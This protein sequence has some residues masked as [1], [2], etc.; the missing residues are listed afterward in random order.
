MKWLTRERCGDSRA[1]RRSSSGRTA[2]PPAFFEALEQRALLSDPTPIALNAAGSG[3]A[4]AVFS[5]FYDVHT[6]SFVAPFS[7]IMRVERIEDQILLSTILTIR[8]AGGRATSVAATPGDSQLSA[9]V[10]RDFAR[11]T[12][13]Q[14]YIIEIMMTGGNTSGGSAHLNVD[15]MPDDH[16]DT[17]EFDKATVI[18]E[19]YGTYSISA[20]GVLEAATD[21]DLFTFTASSYG[22]TD[23]WVQHGSDY[24]TR[25]VRVDVSVFDEDHRLVGSFTGPYS[26]DQWGQV[27]SSGRTVQVRG[28][29]GQRF[30]A[31]VTDSGTN[32]GSSKGDANTYRVQ[33]V[34]NQPSSIPSPLYAPLGGA[35]S[36][37]ANA[38]GDLGLG[39]VS[40]TGRPSMFIEDAGAA[41]S[42]ADL[43]ALVG[44]SKRAGAPATWADPKDNSVGVAAPMSD[45][46]RLAWRDASGGWHE[47]NLT[48]EVAGAGI[49]ASDVTVFTTRD[50][51]LAVS[52]LGITGDLLLY[53]QTGAVGAGGRWEW[54]FT[55]LAANDLR[56]H[57]QSMPKL[58]G[59]LTSYVTDWNGLNIAALDKVGRVQVIWWAPGMEHWRT[60]DLSAL[61]GAPALQ[62]SLSSY[63][64]PWGGINLAG[65]DVNGKVSVTWWAPG[66][67]TWATSNLSD[68]IGGPVLNAGSVA[69]YVTRWGG[70]NV[71]GL[72]AGGRVVVYW[73]APG[74]DAWR[75]DSIS[76]VV[77]D[78]TV[79]S[80]YS[81]RPMRPAVKITGVTNDATGDIN[82]LGV[83]AWG[84]VVRYFWQIGGS[85][86]HENLT[87]AVTP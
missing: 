75:V 57:G 53:T 14:T 84:E 80:G 86:Q 63:L 67:S 33:I 87:V 46:L 81:H 15:R 41:W 52:G 48:A 51:R 16:A 11:V 44:Q 18:T 70:L 49:I 58:I 50:G 1:G 36:G 64:T 7:D 20:T 4:L 45:G 12:A 82:L 9:S 47:R 59:P 38:R 61:T 8:P 55:N 32:F 69:S 56:A 72:D 39:F 83:S 31:L 3:S 28:A 60:D 54:T 10:Y 68:L 65:L 35:V 73:W 13:G 22:L 66:M 21:A 17:G 85:W 71:V 19:P 2:D 5:G 29:P 26:T 79:E 30:Y 37:A 76:D 62:G 43:S 25:H 74:M 6:F 27:N 40:E 42:A 23:V 24:G 78:A 34:T 77:G